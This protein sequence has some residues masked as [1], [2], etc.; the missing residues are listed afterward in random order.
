MSYGTFTVRNW[1]ILRFIDLAVHEFLSIL[2]STVLWQEIISRGLFLAILL[3]EGFDKE[4]KIKFFR[5]NKAVFISSIFFG[6]MHVNNYIFI[7]SL[8]GHIYNTFIIIGSILVG[9]IFGYIRNKTDSLFWPIMMH[10]I[11]NFAEWIVKILIPLILV[12]QLP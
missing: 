2:I 3:K 6:L 4:I 8:Q 11:A 9:Y 5:V 7:T 12:N 1:P 10:T